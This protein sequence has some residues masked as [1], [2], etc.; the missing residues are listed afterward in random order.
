MNYKLGE[1]LIL[2][3]TVLVIGGV[4]TSAFFYMQYKRTRSQLNDSTVLSDSEVTQLTTTVGKLIELPQGEIPTVATVTDVELLK[5]Q[6]FFARAQE[7]DRVL[8]YKTAKKAIL[9]DPVANRIRDVGP[10]N[11]DNTIDSTESASIDEQVWDQ[12]TPTLAP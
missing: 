10:V 4:L 11:I 2:I 8:I 1:W 6:P 5:D 3:L 12:V 9:Y 7:G